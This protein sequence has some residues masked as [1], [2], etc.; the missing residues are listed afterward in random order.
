MG[1][2]ERAP[3]VS[4]IARFKPDGVRVGRSLSQSGRTCEPAG[5]GR[6]A[7]IVCLM[8]GVLAGGLVSSIG[9]AQEAASDLDADPVLNA[10]TDPMLTA[11]LAPARSEVLE[12]QRLDTLSELDRIAGTITL[13]QDTLTALNAEIETLRSDR[14]AIRAAMIEAA[15]KQKAASASLN[16]VEERISKL[17]GEEGV[18]EASLVERRGLLAQVL[19]ALQRMGRKPPPALL[20]K[21]QDALG[22]VRSAILLGSVVPGLRHET[23]VLLADLTRLRDL[24]AELDSEMQRYGD[25]LANF[26]R[27]ETRL[28]RLA[29]TK[30][31]LEAENQDKRTAASERAEELAAK[32]EDLKSLIASLDE[33]VK[34]ARLTE[35]AERARLEAKAEEMRLAAQRQAAEEK[36][37][38]IAEA[39]ALQSEEAEAQQSEIAE[40]AALEASETKIAE[41]D[42]SGPV[43]AEKSMRVAALAPDEAAPALQ[44]YDIDSLRRDIKALQ[45]TAAFSSLKGRLSPPVAGRQLIGFGDRDDIGR[46]VTGAS[47]ATRPGDVVTA[48]ADATVL[49]SGPFRSYGQVLI[50]DAGDDYHVVLAGMDRIDVESGQFVSAGEPVAAMGARR[51]A[52]V[53]MADFG[54]SGPALYVEFRK[55]GKPV[56]PSSWWIDETSGRTG[57]DS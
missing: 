20:V 42:A 52:S 1:G 18:I 5:N 39:E 10:A 12:R 24:R 22:S 37:R 28:D 25:Q 6:L 8:A 40:S 13:N 56:D 19:A 9:R 31:A 43:T 15:E 27:E 16:A 36:A 17:S 7:L 45:P 30:A 32:A 50:L 53:N 4:I 51:I 35:A 47:F 57:N 34:T 29:E 55:A 26:R 38:Q 3:L 21:P 54:A 49:Y 2:L 23:E 33:D 46:V 11:A 14:E 48:P 41:A 44:Q